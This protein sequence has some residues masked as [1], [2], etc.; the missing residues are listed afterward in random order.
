MK[1]EFTRVTDRGQVSIP[2]VVRRKLG[3]H[4]GERIRWEVLSDDSCRI[5]RVSAPGKVGARAMRGYAR[6]FRKTRTTEEWMQELRA[7]DQE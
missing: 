3:L 7:G 5:E 4:P 1:S 2:V 6:E